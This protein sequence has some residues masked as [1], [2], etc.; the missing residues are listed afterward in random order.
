MLK[1]FVDVNPATGLAA[2]RWTI[3]AADLVHVISE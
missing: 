1:V 3:S 2:A